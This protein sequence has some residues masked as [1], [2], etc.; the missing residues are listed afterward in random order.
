MPVIELEHVTKMYGSSRGVTDIS[1]SVEPGTVFGFL[2]PNGAGKST[3]IGMLVDLIRP[4]KGRVSI[5]G[6][7]S[8]KDSV[9]IHR[10]IGYLAGDTALDRG[11]T[12]WQQLEYFGALRGGYDKQRVRE[13]AERL[14]CRLER[15]FKELSRGNKQKVG[16]IAALMHN[17]E[18]LILDEP[19]SGLDPLVQAEF[20]KIILEHKREGKTA[21]I[22]SH[23]LSEVQEICD[24]VTFIREGELIAT[25]QTHE[26]AAESPKQFRIM[27]SDG[28]Q[29]RKALQAIKGVT[30]APAQDGTISGTYQGDVNALLGLLARHKLS[31]FSLEDADLETIFMQYYTENDSDMEPHHA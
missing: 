4:T 7:D 21:F 10:R 13:L 8:V 3:T 9:A 30:L 1:L 25:K 14:D 5:F 12:G 15:R 29:L 24:S 23:V 19:T 16:L 31:D 18:L 11:L 27:A 17:P 20:N 2:G 28:R 6:L 22:S 26:L